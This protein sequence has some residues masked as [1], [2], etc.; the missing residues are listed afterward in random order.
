MNIKNPVACAVDED[1]DIVS[2]KTKKISVEELEDDDVLVSVNSIMNFVAHNKLNADQLKDLMCELEAAARGG[3]LA[4]RSM[5]PTWEFVVRYCVFANETFPELT[6]RNKLPNFESKL[7]TEARAADVRFFKNVYDRSEP[8]H[9]SDDVNW[10][11]DA[12]RRWQATAKER[13]DEI[14]RDLNASAH[15]PGE[16]RQKDLVARYAARH[17]SSFYVTE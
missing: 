10:Q 6:R 4:E 11:A 14:T 2:V 13:L 16:E 8:E 9:R 3:M 12:E 5:A 17:G 1:D 7:T 15:V